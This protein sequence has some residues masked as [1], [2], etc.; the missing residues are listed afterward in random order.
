[1]TFRGY[2]LDGKPATV[3]LDGLAVVKGLAPVAPPQSD[4]R[5]KKPA[6]EKA[7]DALDKVVEQERTTAEESLRRRRKKPK[8]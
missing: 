4:G 8:G 2:G 1:V 7:L 6:A 3:R 5:P